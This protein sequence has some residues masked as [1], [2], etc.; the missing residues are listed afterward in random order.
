MTIP[1]D[2]AASLD[3]LGR[4]N[5]NSGVEPTYNFGGAGG[6]GYVTLLPQALNDVAK[7]GA[8]LSE[9]IAQFPIFAVSTKTANFS[10]VDDDRNKFIRVDSATDV[11]ATLHAAAAPGTQILISQEGTGQVIIAAASGASLQSIV[12]PQRSYGRYAVIGV[13]CVANAGGSAAV[14][15]VGGD[16]DLG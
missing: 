2:V 7:V 11:T 14:W 3:R 1:T 9:Q 13:L 4:Y 5:Y 12:T 16:L 8:Y 6:Y 15:R 10:T